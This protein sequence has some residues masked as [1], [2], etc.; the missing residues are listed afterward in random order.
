V[1]LAQRI[2]KRKREGQ[3]SAWG[4]DL[5]KK[6]LSRIGLVGR[7]GGENKTDQRSG[8]CMQS[9]K[10]RFPRWGEGQR[11]QTEEYVL[12]EKN[13]AIRKKTESYGISAGK[14]KKERLYLRSVLGDKEEGEHGAMKRLKKKQDKMHFGVLVGTHKSRAE[15]IEK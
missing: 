7:G 4:S 11:F 2:L 5:R 1:E 8:S 10:K 3:R 12:T 14:G 9:R 15:R 13:W 6:R